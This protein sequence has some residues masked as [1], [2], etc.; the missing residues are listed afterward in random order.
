MKVLFV[1]NT[2]G[3]CTSIAIWLR[4][5]G[6]EVKVVDMRERDRFGRISLFDESLLCD[7]LAELNS[8]IESTISDWKPDVIHVNSHDIY[9]VICRIVTLRTPI[10]FQFHGSEIR[11]KKKLPINTRLADAIIVSTPDLSEYGTWYGSPTGHI[12]TDKGGRKQG[13]ALLVYDPKSY[14]DERKTAEAFCQTHEIDLTIAQRIPHKE[15]PWLLSKFEYYLDFKRL[16]ALSKIALESSSCGC[17]IFHLDS[18]GEI[19]PVPLADI[20]SCQTNPEKYL[21]LYKSLSTSRARNLLE[22]ISIMRTKRNIGWTLRHFKRRLF[23]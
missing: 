16:N 9:L 2:A 17:I 13:T 7:S 19:Y 23:G 8:L 1:R 3:A 12:F 11:G 15:L 4:E 10:V 20:E 18:Y 21:A 22:L 14:I 5:N 6:Y